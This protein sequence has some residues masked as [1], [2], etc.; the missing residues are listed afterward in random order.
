MKQPRNVSLRLSP[1]QKA[2]LK[3]LAD[4]SGMTFSA[5]LEAILSDAIQERPLY[6]PQRVKEESQQSQHDVAAMH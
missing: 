1:T 5:Y 2:E 6:R 4:A 3:S